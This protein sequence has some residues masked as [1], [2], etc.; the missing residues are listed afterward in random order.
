MLQFNEQNKKTINL[1]SKKRKHKYK[2][3]GV[4]VNLKTLESENHLPIKIFVTISK[5]NQMRSNRLK[6]SSIASNP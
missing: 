4:D 6:N 5:S 1:Q 3:N 2:E